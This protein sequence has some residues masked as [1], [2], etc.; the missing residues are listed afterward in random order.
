[1]ALEAGGSSPLT[2]PIFLKTGQVGTAAL[3]RFTFPQRY[4]LPWAT[5]FSI[6][7]AVHR[8]GRGPSKESGRPGPC[9]MRAWRNRQTR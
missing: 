7:V 5:H 3:P 8:N 9:M 2:H 1:M 6:M 4:F